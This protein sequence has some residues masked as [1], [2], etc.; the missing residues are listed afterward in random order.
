MGLKKSRDD[1]DRDRILDRESIIVRHN[2]VEETVIA[3]TVD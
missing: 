3:L 2:P 1:D